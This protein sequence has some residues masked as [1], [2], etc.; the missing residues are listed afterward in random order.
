LLQI[1]KE[2]VVV[3][4]GKE[5]E[6]STSPPAGSARDEDALR[7][8]ALEEVERVRKFKLHLTLFVVG[9][10]LLTGL[11]ALTEYLE[12][13]G[14]PKSFGDE[15]VPHMWHIWIF[16]VVGAWALLVALKGV[17]AYFRRSPSEVEVERAVERLR[18]RG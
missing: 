2:V 15:D 12:A 7:T 17:A 9:T 16:Y 4:T 8:L 11:W 13:G 6:A 5:H 18:P 3:R 10:I 1:A 14:W